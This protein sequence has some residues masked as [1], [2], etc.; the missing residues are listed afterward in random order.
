MPTSNGQINARDIRQKAIKALHMT[1]D[2]VQTAAIEALAVTEAKI[3]DP[4]WT[5]AAEA[6]TVAG[7]ALTTTATEWISHI[8]DV[9]SWVGTISILSIGTLQPR[10]SSGGVQGYRLSVR[11]NDIQS[12]LASGDVPDGSIGGVFHF[13]SLQLSS[14]GSTVQVSVYAHTATGTNSDNFLALDI[15][16]FGVR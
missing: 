15:I 6:P 1:A 5:Y 10:N 9:P 14:P 8:I 11:Y 13:E 12:G 3:E 4:V 7:V 2:S 16:A